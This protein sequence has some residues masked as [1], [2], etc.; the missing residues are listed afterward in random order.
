[1]SMNDSLAC[2]SASWET[3]ADPHNDV[4]LDSTLLID[5]IRTAT[6]LSPIAKIAELNVSD[7]DLNSSLIIST[8]FN[9]ALSLILVC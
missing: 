6:T 1:M 3:L 5:V 4:L 9:K 2:S 8:S 7:I